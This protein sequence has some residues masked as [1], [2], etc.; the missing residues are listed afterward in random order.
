MPGP[1][2]SGS[3]V[4]PTSRPAARPGGVAGYVLRGAGLNNHGLRVRVAREQAR[5]ND[6]AIRGDFV[7]LDAG[8][9]IHSAA[10]RAPGAVVSEDGGG[11]P[12]AGRGPMDAAPPGR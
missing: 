8:D 4:T 6:G 5:G 10:V 1:R 9:N 3:C 2:W 11:A 7:I 12:S